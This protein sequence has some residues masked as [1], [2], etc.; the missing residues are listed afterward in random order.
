MGTPYETD[1]VAWAHEQ[2]A[3]LRSGNL[4]AIDALNIAEEIDDV[5]RAERR[6]LK[7]RMSVLVAHL[8]K[9]KFQADHRGSSW[10]STIR[11][12]RDEIGDALDEMPSLKHAF[13]DERLLRAIWRNAVTI[14]HGET[15]LSF[16]TTWIWSIEQVL[17]R[18]FWPD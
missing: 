1:V 9:W 16:P 14:A 3:L 18:D 17:D 11:L 4:S 7:S 13:E 6:E 12:Q 2:A 5:A 8:L 15:R 10:V